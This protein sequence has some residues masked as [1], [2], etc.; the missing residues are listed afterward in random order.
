MELLSLSYAKFNDLWTD[1]NFALNY[2]Q[3]PSDT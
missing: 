3:N 1:M 2:L